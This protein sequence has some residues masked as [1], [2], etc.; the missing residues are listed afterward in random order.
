MD[1][2]PSLLQTLE[3]F[4]SEDPVAEAFFN[5]HDHRLYAEVMEE[6]IKELGLFVDTLS[7]ATG[8]LFE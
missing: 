6:Y 4:C 7:P 5:Q 8:E 2:C 1:I 3:Q